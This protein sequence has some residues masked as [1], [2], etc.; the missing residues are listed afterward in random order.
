M[1]FLTSKPWF[2]V[3][4]CSVVAF[5]ASPVAGGG[6]T[7]SGSIGS[8]MAN[9]AIRIDDGA[10]KGNAA[11]FPG[12]LVETAGGA[13]ELRLRSGGA[14]VMDANTK[15]RVFENRAEIE[16]GK[17]QFRGGAAAE[18][19][20]IRVET[21]DGSEAIVERSANSLV[22]GSLRGAVRVKDGNGILLASLNPG[23]AMAF[24]AAEEDQGGASPNPQ[25]TAGGT[26]TRR[27]VR[28][29]S[30]RFWLITG[31]AGSVLVPVTVAATRNNN[32]PASR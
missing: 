12:N 11:L 6:S 25:T 24:T 2:A 13:S 7:G 1:T 20:N 9:S 15:L 23:N 27:M 14:V 21:A 8:V 30:R 26:K 17:A 29:G 16:A 28:I 19:G 3:A 18:S 4:A 10:V 5:A 32:P 22:V 31:T